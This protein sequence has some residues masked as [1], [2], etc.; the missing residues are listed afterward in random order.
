MSGN[1]ELAFS[2]IIWPCIWQN[3]VNERIKIKD[4]VNMCSGIKILSTHLV[5]P[6][7]FWIDYAFN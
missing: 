5:K 3:R 7:Q 2:F 1:V 4:L 6:N